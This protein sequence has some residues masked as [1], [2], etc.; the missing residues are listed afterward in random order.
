M[1]VADVSPVTIFTSI[2]AFAHSLTAPGTSSL[3]GS[4]MAAMPCNV[5]AF[6]LVFRSKVDVSPLISIYANA[7]VRMACI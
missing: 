4:L 3:S 7:S 1:A 2:P 5:R 6:P